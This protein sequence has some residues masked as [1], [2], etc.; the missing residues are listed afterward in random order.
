MTHFTMHLGSL[1]GVIVAWGI[2]FGIGNA[3][4]ETLSQAEDLFRHGAYEKCIEV[5][6]QEISGGRTFIDWYVL[7]TESE[8]TLG[9]YEDAAKT[10]DDAKNFSPRNL[11][12]LWLEREVRHFNGQSN[13][14]KEVLAELGA[15]LERSSG[16]YRDLETSIVIGKFFLEIGADPKRI[17]IDLFKPIQKRAPGLPAAYI[18]AAELALSKNDFALAAED[19]QLAMK[20]DE[21]NPRILYGLAQAFEPS[22]SKKAEEYLQQAIKINPKHI[23]SLLMIAESHLSAERYKETEKL[24]AE[25]LEINPHHPSAW[26][27]HAVL[28]HLANAPSREDEC[29]KKALAHWKDNPE[30]DYLIGKHLARKYR[31]AEAASAQRRALKFDSD[32]LPAKME[33]SNDLL[34]LGHEE[35]GWKLVDEVFEADNYNVVA[36]NLAT[37]QE[38]MAKFRTLESNGFIVRMDTHEAA[39]YGDRVLELLREAKSVLCEKYDVELND[40]IAIEIFPKQQDFA[41]R[42]FGLPGGAGFLGVCFGNVITMNSPASQA[43]N[44]TNWE[45]VLWHEFCHVVTLNKTHNKMPRWLSE[46]I[47]VYEEKL[48]DPSWGQSISPTYRQMILEDELTPVSELSGAF[49]RPQSSKHLMFAYYE[50]ALVVEFLVDQFGIETLRAILDELGK[51]LQI[52]DAIT[53]HAAPLDAIDAGFQKFI[54]DRARAFAPE[55][56]FSTDDLP[57]PQIAKLQPWLEEHPNSFPGL[58]QY[59][60]LLFREKKYAEAMEPIDKLL[61]LAPDY[62]GEGSPL[63]LKAQILK[64]LGETQQELAVLEQ[65]AVL[66]ADAIDIYRRLA[67]MQAETNQWESVVLN[68]R[69]IRAVNPLIQE[70]YLLLARAGEQTNDGKTAIEGLSTLSRLDPYDPAE[71]HFRLAQRLHASKQDKEALRHILLALEEA[72]R[73]RDA[74]QLL[75][76]LTENDS[77]EPDRASPNKDDSQ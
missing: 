75:L 13:R 3:Y 10:I 20:V 35:Q 24:L 25:V 37:L 14:A 23:P 50:S 61:Q 41:I 18:A 22:D 76:A 47:S 6:T 52:N 67:E 55:A 69:R 51:G 5:A 44:P 38:H 28:A 73:Y 15:Q 42:T 33:L 34:R 53:R 29:R 54:L 58:Q 43:D 36:H 12:L 21:D 63:L 72:P 39:I 40:P 65:L 57:P 66:R 30:V 4:G 60:A 17:R 11:R 48:R 26:A 1:A 16:I 46:G 49:L 7:K 77:A 9:R 31:F 56:D 19:F 62:A 32:F 2:F 27:L 8:L 74:L 45:A 59:A 68:A 70:P 71:I 64:E